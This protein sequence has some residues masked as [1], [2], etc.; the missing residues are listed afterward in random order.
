MLSS[1]FINA[2]HEKWEAVLFYANEA[3]DYGLSESGKIKLSALMGCAYRKIKLHH[4]EKEQFEHAEALDVKN[5]WTLFIGKYR[6][7]ADERR[8]ITR[9]Q[10]EER[11]ESFETALQNTHENMCCILTLYSS[12]N[13]L[14]TSES[15]VS[16]SMK[17][18]ELLS[19]LS[20]NKDGFVSRKKILDNI[21]PEL[22]SDNPN[23]TVVKR[24]ISS[25]RKKLSEAFESHLGMEFIRFEDNGYKLYLPVSIQVFKGV[26]SRRISCR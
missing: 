25:L 11:E 17:E 7:L 1:A 22:T 16:L 13:C 9:L 20:V 4:R 23:S 12:Y 8:A 6:D 5:E 19:F 3:L 14:I 2:H 24:N 21:W 15:E 26:D 10:R 18:A